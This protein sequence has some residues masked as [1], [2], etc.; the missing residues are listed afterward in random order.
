MRADAIV[1][2]AAAEGEVLV[3]LAGKVERVWVVED[4]SVA[5]G[6][7]E[8][9]DDA[10]A[11]LD[12]DAADLGVLRRRAAEVPDGR[13]DAHELVDGLVRNAAG[14][15]ELA[16]RAIVLEEREQAERHRLACCLVARD[17]EEGKVV[18]EV[19][20]AKWAATDLHVG[21]DR[22]H[23]VFRRAPTCVDRLAP[24]GTQLS[25]CLTAEGEVLEGL[26]L[27]RASD[28][29]RDL[30]VGVD[31]HPIAEFDQ[32]VEL[33]G[34]Q[35]EDRAEHADRN[36]RGD[37]VDKADVLLL[38]GLI[39]DLVDDHPQLVFVPADRLRCEV[40]RKRLAPLVVQRR[41]GLHK[42]AARFEHVGLDMTNARRA[43][44]LGRERLGALEHIED[45]VVFRHAP[46][47][48]VL[49]GVPIDGCL[50]LHPFEDLPRLT[51]YEQAVVEQVELGNFRCCHGGRPPGVGVSL[52]DW[53]Q[54]TILGSIGFTTD[55]S[56]R[57]TRHRYT[58]GDT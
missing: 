5:V 10:F 33:L 32:A 37:V 47:P 1:R 34:W 48:V 29:N 49:I 39:E 3:L 12:L 43:T 38:E 54:N 36:Q 15:R 21:E 31:N 28:V 41:V 46:E 2:T 17:D 44:G 45:I 25:R 8:P 50:A 35:A 7:G 26:G 14:L 27:G 51:I 18:V 11:L 55:A 57:S 58:H 6:W 52:A 22:E 4:L 42:V 56:F 20:I 53:I 30:G 40:A 23:I 24:H 19:A 13:G 9:D 16:H